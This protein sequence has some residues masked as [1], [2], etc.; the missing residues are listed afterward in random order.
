MRAIRPQP[1][2]ALWVAKVDRGGAGPQPQSLKAQLLLTP[3]DA[4]RHQQSES[5]QPKQSLGTEETARKV[6]AED[7]AVVENCGEAREMFAAYVNDCK[8][9][10]TVEFGSGAE[11]TVAEAEHRVKVVGNQW[12][13][14]L[15]QVGGSSAHTLIGII[16]KARV[17]EGYFAECPTHDEIMGVMRSILRDLEGLLQKSSD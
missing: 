3:S 4:E 15:R 2:R 1:I 14:M 7:T 13:S 9:V 11:S 16:A 5:E 6:D 17:V 12:R 10:E 8:N